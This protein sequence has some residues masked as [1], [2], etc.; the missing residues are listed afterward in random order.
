MLKIRVLITTLLIAGCILF[1]A[2]PTRAENRPEELYWQAIEAQ[3]IA[4]MM[5]TEIP[6]TEIKDSLLSHTRVADKSFAKSLLTHWKLNSAQNIQAEFNQLVLRNHN[7]HEIFRMTPIGAATDKFSVNGKTWFVPEHGSVSESL[8]AVLAIAKTGASL[9]DLIVPRAYADLFQPDLSAAYLYGTSIER[10]EDLRANSKYAMTPEQ[11][12]RTWRPEPYLIRSEGSVGDRLW[13]H[14][15]GKP[16]TVRC[17]ADTATGHVRLA[18]ENLSFSASA[19]DDSVVLTSAESGKSFKVSRSGVTSVPSGKEIPT[20]LKFFA[21]RDV[22]CTTTVGSD[23]H[24]LTAFFDIKE[25]TAV[26]IATTFRPRDGDTFVYPIERR[27]ENRADCPLLVIRNF[28]KLS[29]EDRARASKLRDEAN[30]AIV[31]Q[32][33]ENNQVIRS[34]MPLGECCQSES[35]RKSVIT[36]GINLEPAA[37]TSGG[38][39]SHP[40][41]VV[42]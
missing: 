24:S 39:A 41:N 31:K 17:S 35:C 20:D 6:S 25:E 36:Q 22:A 26:D 10:R 7:G 3:N 34:V 21:C 42:H 4:A 13:E 28:E 40:K 1:C 19:H 32:E 38:N 23:K 16:V 12:L 5:R 9:F 27:C 37:A 29:A 30:L 8:K 18:G 33:S 11:K 2:Q 15:A 14:F